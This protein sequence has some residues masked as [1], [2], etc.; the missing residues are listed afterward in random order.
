MN[1]ILRYSFALLLACVGFTAQAQKYI[2]AD[3]WSDVL[4]EEDWTGWTA[5]IDPMSDPLNTGG[6]SFTGTT[7]KEEDGSYKG[8]TGIYNENLAGGEAPELLIAKNGGTLMVPI[9]FPPAGEYG[10]SNIGGTYTLSFK[11]NKNITVTTDIGT[12]GEPTVVGNDYTYPLTLETGTMSIIITFTN[13]LS[14]NARFDN[15][16]LTTGEGKK[17]AGLSY[18]TSS[19]TVTIGAD[20]NVFPELQNANN[21]PVTYTSSV[22]DVAT[23]DADGVITLVAPGK[24]IIKAEFAGNDEYEAGYAQYELTVKE[25]A[26]PNA[27]GGVNNP[28]TVTEALAVLA[29]MEANAKT[30]QVYVTGVINSITEIS[31]EHGNATFN[32]TDDTNGLLVYRA[33]YLNKEN[34]TDEAQLMIGDEVVICGQLTNYL[35]NNA[36]EGTDPT[37]EFTQGCY[38]Y[39]IQ[40]G[41]GI[42][43]VNVAPNVNG[44]I[45]NLA[46]QRVDENYRGIVIK[47]GKKVMQ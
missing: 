38:V 32:I 33:K 21:L 8:G 46:G 3:V 37:P 41:T 27:K 15:V 23:I 5:K 44:A 35:S 31:L 24:T 47:N 39:S 19:R 43:N 16:K 29:T 1:K 28:Y 11:C 12:L 25:G 34:F 36:P 6:Y 20:D 10:M 4:W 9:E 45:Y 2:Q 17:P 26:D 13:N 40:S 42:N 14:S 7:Y 22:T 30:D 18:G